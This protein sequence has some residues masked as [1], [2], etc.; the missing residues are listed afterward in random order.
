MGSAVSTDHWAHSNRPIDAVRHPLGQRPQ[1][2]SHRV[3]STQAPTSRRPATGAIGPVV[4]YAQSDEG[5][6]F[7]SLSTKG[8]PLTEMTLG[9]AF[10]PSSSRPDSSST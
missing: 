9:P 3:A 6:G 8:L 2:T 5:S 1:A 4:A 10:I 7:A